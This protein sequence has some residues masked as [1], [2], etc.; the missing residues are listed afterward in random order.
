MK[1]LCSTWS[2]CRSDSDDD[3]EEEAVE[4]DVRK[5]NYCFTKW[6]QHINGYSSLLQIYYCSRTHTQLAQFVREVQKS[7]YSEDVQVITLGSRQVRVPSR[8]KCLLIRTCLHT[9]THTHTHTQACQHACT[10]NAQQAQN[11]FINNVL[12]GQ[13]LGC[14]PNL[15]PQCQLINI[16]QKTQT[17][18]R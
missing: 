8:V 9:H 2:F 10:Y 6:M 3:K 13:A 4:S 15:C 17:L 11:V 5:V 1:I 18:S 12:A 14:L 16:I 7:P